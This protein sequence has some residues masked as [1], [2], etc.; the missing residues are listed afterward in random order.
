[1]QTRRSKRHNR[2]RG[3]FHTP[4][5][6]SPNPSYQRRRRAVCRR[7]SIDWFVTTIIDN[8]AGQSQTP[9]HEINYTFPLGTRGVA[10]S[11]SCAG[12]CVRV[13][14]GRKRDEV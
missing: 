11:K 7:S 5:K 6:I 1:M 13:Y 10:G 14:E 2:I 12:S 9:L 4:Q 3:P 8:E